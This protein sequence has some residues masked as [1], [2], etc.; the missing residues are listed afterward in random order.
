[1]LEKGLN[2]PASWFPPEFEIL[3]PT[4]PAGTSAIV[5]VAQTV[6]V[7]LWHETV[8]PPPQGSPKMQGL[9]L[10]QR[11]ASVPTMAPGT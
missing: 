2:W 1:M 7:S 4:T 6:L 9:G 5:R 11:G 10:L 8:D 3:P